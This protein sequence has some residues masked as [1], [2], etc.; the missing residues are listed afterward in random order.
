MYLST[1]KV[2]F[3]H[4]KTIKYFYIFLKRSL[5]SRPIIYKK[6]FNLASDLERTLL[7]LSHK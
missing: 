4:D 6:A 1:Y 2:N 7:Q 3:Q 5:Y